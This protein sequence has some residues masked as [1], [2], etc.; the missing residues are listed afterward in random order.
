[1]IRQGSDDIKN[2][3]TF[4]LNGKETVEKSDMGI[5]KK[6]AKWSDDKNTLTITKIM[7]FDPGVSTAEYRIDDTYKL[8]DNGKTLVIES[9]SKN[10][11]GERKTILVYNKK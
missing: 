2:N 6:I 3:D 1:M 5:T 10:P 4:Y 7:T 8:I 9:F 11:A